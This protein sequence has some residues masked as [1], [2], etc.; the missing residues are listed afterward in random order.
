MDDLS[1]KLSGILNDPESLE[2][3]KSMAESAIFSLMIPIPQRKKLNSLRQS[4]QILNGLALSGLKC[5]TH[6]TFLTIFLSL[7]LN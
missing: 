2:Q 6:Q 1:E 7:P 3:L 4:R 5:I